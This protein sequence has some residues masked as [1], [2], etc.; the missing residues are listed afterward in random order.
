ME[1]IITAL[2]T[3]WGEG[4]IAVVRLSG[5]GS[6]L[7]AD[8]IFTG[9][10]KLAEQPA[11]FLTLGRLR[12]SKGEFF[13]EVLTVRFDKGASYT[14]EESVEIH[15][16]G[17]LLPAQKCME[18]LCSMG[19]RL[20]Q[21]GEFTRRAFVN[22]RIDL[23]QA[24]AVL[25]VIRAE[26][27]EALY[28]SSRTLQGSFAEKLRSFLD[29]ITGLAAFLEV[30]LD[31][32]EEDEGYITKTD[33]EKRLE[34]LISAGEAL[35]ADCRSG[36]ILREG[37]KTAIIGCPNVGKSSLLNA[38]L[39]EDRAIV[40]SVPGTTRDRIEETFTHKGIPIRIIDTA[41][42][43][44]TMD[45]VECIGVNQS[46]KSMTEADL[47]VWVIDAG[48]ELTAE[49]ME[50]G[51]RVSSMKHIVVL[52]KSDIPQ[53]ISLDQLKMSFPLSR[54]VSVSALKSDG[55][56]ELKDIMVNEITG[57]IKVTG[58]YGVTSRQIECLSAAL[59]SLRETLKIVSEGL[60]NDL[61]ITCLSDSR[62]ELAKL[63]GIDATENLLD[64]IFSQFC[65][66]K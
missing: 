13:D 57:G 16:H 47:R 51:R 1:D 27:D 63:L 4:G 61:A 12:S 37:I 30:D 40:T 31:F 49:D 28:A 9:Q 60:G 8:K 10:K 62:S 45:E 44:E 29:D 22:G 17:G 48:D 56:E 33:S 39:K 3:A 19:A 7:L 34:D 15:C 42:I 26:S 21:P 50:L 55:I 54:I 53:K 38:L 20:A 32:P 24:E 52:N 18:E 46:I 25:G 66:G 11:R 36:L 5:E 2:A 64:T 41:G 65:V 35:L 14:A 23:P 6:V 43:R 59:T 58:G